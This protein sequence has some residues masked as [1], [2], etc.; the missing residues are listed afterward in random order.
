GTARRVARPAGRPR[1]LPP[2]GRS[3]RRGER[4]PAPDPGRRPRGACGGPFPHYAARPGGPGAVLLATRASPRGHQPGV[5]RGGGGPRGQRAR[6]DRSPGRL[7]PRPLAGP[8]QGT[9]RGLPAVGRVVCP[10]PP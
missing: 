9:G 2:V 1:R 10:S 4:T 3:A 7:P 5:R 8:L 6:C